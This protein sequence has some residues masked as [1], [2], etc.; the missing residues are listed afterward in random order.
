MRRATV[1]IPDGLEKALDSY[2]RDLEFPPSLA[3]VMQAALKEY[4]SRRGYPASGEPIPGEGPTVYEDVPTLRGNK[5]VAEMVIEDCLEEIF[6]ITTRFLQ[7]SCERLESS[8]KKVL[9][10]IWDNASCA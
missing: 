6:G 10:L 8:G 7:W 9:L 5:T 3:A 4:L 2:A 1:T